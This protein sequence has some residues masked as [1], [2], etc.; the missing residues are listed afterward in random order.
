M[1]RILPIA[2]FLLAFVPAMSF[3]QETTKTWPELKA[4][5]AVMSATFH[6]AEEGNLAP[7]KARAGEL[8]AAVKKWK[9]AEIPAD[10]KK[11][12]TKATL[13]E[14]EIKCGALQ[15]AVEARQADEKIKTLLTEAHNIF[16]KIVGEC[17]NP[18]AE[19]N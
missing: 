14:L 2:I 17:R 1:K 9:E 18:T 13:I 10:F 3:A 6:P 16:H 15:K 7:I 12:E 19:H 11:K 4:F 5:H 8:F